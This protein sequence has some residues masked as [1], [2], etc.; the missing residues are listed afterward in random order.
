M[1]AWKECLEEITDALV[2]A[3]GKVEAGIGV[4]AG[5]YKGLLTQHKQTFQRKIDK[6]DDEIRKL[7]VEITYLKA[8]LSVIKPNKNIDLVNINRTALIYAL[9][10]EETG[11]SMDVL[12]PRG[13]HNRGAM[14][15][16]SPRQIVA[17]L[18]YMFV[19]KSMNPAAKLVGYS[20][21][22]GVR[23]ALKTI[24]KWQS[25]PN[26]YRNEMHTL[27][28]VTAALQQLMQNPKSW[29]MQGSTTGILPDQSQEV[30]G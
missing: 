12:K 23:D 13:R 28:R 17:Y 1:D 22:N 26:Q 7:K 11:L 21:H 15:V 14:Q 5:S 19:T 2:K 18:T 9:V 10:S 20:T 4:R 25:H 6:K 30:S 27:N 24:A 8:E 29:G 16:T 3:R